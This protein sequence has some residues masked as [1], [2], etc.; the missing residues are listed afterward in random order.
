MKWEK[1]LARK[2]V[3]QH[4]MSRREFKGAGFSLA[5]APL[6]R[7]GARRLGMDVPLIIPSWIERHTGRMERNL[8]SHAEVSILTTLLGEK[9]EA[10]KGERVKLEEKGDWNCVE[11]KRFFNRV[12]FDC[13]WVTSFTLLDL[14]GRKLGR[15]RADMKVE[16]ITFLAPPE[17]PLEDRTMCRV[18]DVSGYVEY[19]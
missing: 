17:L 13:R 5:Y 3:F 1:L 14:H 9:P 11:R 6:T 7:E 8:F 16:C 18:L 2:T 10:Y 15:G 4:L 19:D 12:I